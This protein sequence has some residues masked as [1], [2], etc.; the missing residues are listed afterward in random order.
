MSS[1]NATNDDE[2]RE[3]RDWELV[4]DL[5]G[6]S[7]KSLQKMIEHHTEAL[8]VVT[9][10]WEGRCKSRAKHKRFTALWESMEHYDSG[11]NGPTPGTKARLVWDYLQTRDVAEPAQIADAIG[12]A[13]RNVQS[14]LASRRELFQ[15]TEDGWQLVVRAEECTV[16]STETIAPAC[17]P[18]ETSDARLKCTPEPEPDSDED[19]R[20]LIYE[21]LSRMG[22]KKPAVIAAEL[23]IQNTRLE[24]LLDHER[25]QR[26]PGGYAIA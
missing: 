21:Y 25:F 1:D 23:A 26:T 14:V 4:F 2:D 11:D 19:L 5:L 17:S 10:L 24:H 8:A 18:R 15:H 16:I 13:K 7:D 20:T 3:D 12:L 9:A 6:M 22:A